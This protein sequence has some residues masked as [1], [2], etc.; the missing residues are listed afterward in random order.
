MLSA[1]CMSKYTE[2]WGVQIAGMIFQT[3][4]SIHHKKSS[5]RGHRNFFCVIISLYGRYPEYVAV[6]Y[7]SIKQ[8]IYNKI[9]AEQIKDGFWFRFFPGYRL[10]L[11]EV[12]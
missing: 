8:L 9:S 3:L 2:K 11:S 6:I 1:R 5:G 10:W 12:K 7:I 4:W